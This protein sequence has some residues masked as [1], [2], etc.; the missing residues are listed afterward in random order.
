MSTETAV[1]VGPVASHGTAP[2]QWN[3]SHG[4]TGLEISKRSY[5]SQR[6][7]QFVLSMSKDHCT[8]DIRIAIKPPPLRWS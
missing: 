2:E 1:V 8:K 7:S 5:I 3:K 6:A 4:L